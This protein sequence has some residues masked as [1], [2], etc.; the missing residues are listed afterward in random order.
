MRNI[1][2]VNTLFVCGYQFALLAFLPFYFYYFTPGRGIVLATLVLVLLTGISIT[3][4]YHR[5]Y[6]HKAYSVNKTVES[7]LLFFSTMASMGSVLDWASEHRLHHRFVDKE[8]DPYNI[9]RGFFYAHMLWFFQKRKKYDPT[10]VP[11]LIDSKLLRFQHRHVLLLHIVTNT[12]VLLLFGWLCGD[13]FGALVMVIGLRMFIVHHGTWFINSAAH[14]WGEKTYSRELSAVDNFFLALLTFGEGYHNYHHVF[15][16]DYR[17]G[18]RWY[19]YDPTKWLIWSLSKIGL[20]NS[21]VRIDTL[22]SKKRIIQ[23]DTHIFVEAL[24]KSTSEKRE[25]LEQKVHELSEK[26]IKRLADMRLAILEY[27]QLKK[28]K[29]A[30]F[31]EKRQEIRIQRL[32]AKKEWKSW[33][34]LGRE[35]SQIVPLNYHH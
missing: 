6:S 21:L 4:G 12:L 5:F 8:N 22:T 27:R 7:I 9:N 26:L 35:I 11:D 23:E 24:R 3:A 10:V 19:H 29:N 2:W 14:Y 20:A 13:F 16:S 1:D 28:E 17:N 18:I 33:L 15:A 30:Q 25:M 32:L 31:K 34:N